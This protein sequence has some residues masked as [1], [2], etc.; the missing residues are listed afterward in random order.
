MRIRSSLAETDL[1]SWG[2]SD[3][4][5]SW[6]RVTCNNSTRVV[7]LNLDGTNLPGPNSLGEVGCWN[8]SLAIFA[9]FRELQLLDLS[10]HS[11]CLQNFDGTYSFLHF[12]GSDRLLVSTPVLAGISKDLI[13]ITLKPSFSKGLQALTNLRY[14]NLSGNF[15]IV[16]DILESVGK[17]ASLE[18]IN[19]YLGSISG[20]LQNTGTQ[21]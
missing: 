19:F 4:C 17:L 10:G 21:A 12:H 15:L 14:L 1:D 6:E 5:C 20:A 3:D 7:G 16:N 18:V 8:L 9:S 2:H 11:A 13:H